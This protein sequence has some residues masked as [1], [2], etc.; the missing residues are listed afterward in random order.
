VPGRARDILVELDGAARLDL[1]EQGRD[2]LARE[3]A[4]ALHDFAAESLDQKAAQ[5]AVLGRIHVGGVIGRIMREIGQQL[6]EIALA[7]I[8]ERGAFE[9]LIAHR[10]LHAERGENVSVA[11]DDPAMRLLVP[12]DRIIL[13]P[14]GDDIEKLVAE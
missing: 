11:G 4:Y 5:P 14:I 12:A 3:A 2:P 8:G 6:G 10:H 9:P 1:V 7:G 13:A